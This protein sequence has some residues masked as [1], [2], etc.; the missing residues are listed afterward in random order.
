MKQRWISILLVLAMLCTALT[1][2]GGASTGDGGGSASDAPAAESGDQAET[3]D[4]QAPGEEAEAA[5]SEPIE[6]TA[7]LQLNPE[8]VLD[9]NPII[10]M[11]EDELNIRLK[12]EAPPPRAATATGSRCWSPPA[13]CLTWCSTAPTPLPSS[14]QRRAWC[15]M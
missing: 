2:C 11:I 15:W 8:I 5:D 6:I 12:V 1:A 10:Q 9:G 7:V 3:P 14:G 4:A 13:I